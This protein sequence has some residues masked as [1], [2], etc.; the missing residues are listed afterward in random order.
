[1]L[2]EIAETLG[3]PRSP[4]EV[5]RRELGLAVTPYVKAF[6]EDYLPDKPLQPYYA[7]SS[8]T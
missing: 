5:A 7:P 3:K 8:R 4:E 2:A 1:M 6:Y